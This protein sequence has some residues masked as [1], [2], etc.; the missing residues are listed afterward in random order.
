MDKIRD[1]FWKKHD[2]DLN[3]F[4]SSYSDRN[5]DDEIYSIIHN[6]LKKK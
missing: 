4:Q 6:E 5:S 3:D 2:I 1:Y